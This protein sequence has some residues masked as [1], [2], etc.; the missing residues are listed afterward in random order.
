MALVLGVE[1]TAH[2]IGIG[3]VNTEGKILA[4]ARATYFPKKGGILPR[5]AADFISEN[6]SKVLKEA[7]AQAKVSLKE[8]DCF[9]FSQGPGLGGCLKIGS[10]VTRYLAIKHKKPLIGVVH[11]IGHI[12]IGK[13]LTEAKDPVILYVSGGNT[14]VIALS[15]GRYR[16]F[17]ETLDIPIGNCLDQFALQ[18]G[19]KHPG[20]PE[21][22]K[23]ALKGKNYIELPYIVK[24]MDLSFTGL[25]TS[26]MKLH[27]TG[28][29]SLEDLAFSLQETAYAMLIEVTERA[30]AHT[31]KKEV[32]IVGGVAANKRFCEMLEIMAKERNAKAYYV[33]M[34]YAADN[35]TMIAWAGALM[36][37]SGVKQELSKTSVR[38]KFR[39]DEVDVTWT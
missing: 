1:S 27:K 36:L 11:G 26:A 29:Y 12:E 10:N 24:G 6:Y 15:G 8:I 2:T 9:A 18:V 34:K 30:M 37:K 3:I 28:K 23:L 14:Q 5:E 25:L 35:G 13:L 33:P 4:D 32:L 7:L 22:E 39:P 31:N 20:G 38:Q 16:V 19:L 21:V 17:G